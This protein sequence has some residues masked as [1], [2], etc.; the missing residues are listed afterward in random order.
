MVLGFCCYIY[1]EDWKDDSPHNDGTKNENR[2]DECVDSSFEREGGGMAI[3]SNFGFPQTKLWDM[4]RVFALAL[5]IL[6]VG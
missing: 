2:D 6:P 1:S 4:G 5:N 3:C